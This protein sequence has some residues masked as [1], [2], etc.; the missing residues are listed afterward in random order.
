MQLPFAESLTRDSWLFA[1][2]AA[3]FLFYLIAWLRIGSEPKSG[4]V[5]VAYEPPDN[6]SAA[7]VR[8]VA[9]GT[10]DGRSFAAVIAQLAV[11]GCIRVEPING[12]YKLSRL[13]NDRAT[14]AALMPEEQ[15]V[16]RL[17]FTD[18]PEIVLSPSLDERNSAQ[19]ALY[20]NAI[21]QELV[22]RSAGKYLNRHGGVIALGVLATGAAALVF[23]VVMYGRELIETVFMTVWILF[24][25]LVLGMMIEM[26]V[27]SSVRAGLRSGKRLGAL[28]PGV[29]AIAIFGGAV[30]F[31][32]SQLARDVSPAYAL[33]LVAL[34][35]VNL[36]WAPFL[37]RKSALGRKTCDQIAGFR[38]FLE[39]VEQD[40]LNRMNSSGETPMELDK[41]L[42]Y[43]IAL[44]VKEAWGDHLAQSLL[45]SVVMVE[46]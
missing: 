12:K 32:L 5:V 31:L 14:E 35:A 7:A 46:G 39:K 4:A 25:G 18:G 26:S 30:A 36:G 15:R 9:S 37:K 21:H 41:Y 40:R 42:P 23:A 16:L 10:T 11:H 6:L 45:A 2:P 38:Q 20:V 1:A 28:L 3:I 33:M 44:A 19:N 17:L 34:M 24:V 8:Y 27:A 22:K 43:A 29:G 13:M